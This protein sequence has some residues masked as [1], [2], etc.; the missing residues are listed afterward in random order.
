LAGVFY[1]ALLALMQL[2]LRRLLAFASVNQTGMLVVGVFCLNRDG[3]AGSLLLA[4]NFGVAA[5]ALLLASGLLLHR[6]GSSLLPRLGE[7]FD[8]M[9]LLAMTFLVAALSTVAMPGTP[10]FDAA[11]MLL[12]GAIQT[13]DWA[14]SVAIA[15]GN[16]LAAAFLL[17]AFQQ[18]FLAHRRESA[19]RPLK[20]RVT[21]LEIALNGLV[22]AGLLGVGFYS[23]PWLKVVDQSVRDLAGRFDAY[24]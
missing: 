8:P 14:I 19:I 2:N 22:C 17:R 16:V 15:V 10:G 5:S 9:P 3:L 24:R 12:E 21:W 1:G 18:V 13:H 23:E 20:V 4:I 7:L 11:H 6:A